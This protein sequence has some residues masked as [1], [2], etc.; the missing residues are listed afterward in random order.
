MAMQ[1]STGSGAAA[2]SGRCLCLGQDDPVTR[3]DKM[4]QLELLSQDHERVCTLLDL[5][6]GAFAAGCAEEGRKSFAHFSSELERHLRL[7]EDLVFRELE[8]LHSS[9]G[10]RPT[11]SLWLEH[12]E[13]RELLEN[14]WYHLKTGQDGLPVLETLRRRL[15]EHR[16][17]EQS[18]IRAALLGLKDQAAVRR[19]L[20]C[21]EFSLQW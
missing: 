12:G 5:V 1:M 10:E 4:Q 17:H 19:L 14:A 6:C 18:V 21:L 3:E 11:L 8:R 16:L 13:I 2:D 7:E 20:Q 9:A 15:N